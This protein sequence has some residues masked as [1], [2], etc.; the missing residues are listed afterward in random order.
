MISL[1]KR[2]HSCAATTYF[3]VGA[4]MHLYMAWAWVVHPRVALASLLKECLDTVF[5]PI[6][7]GMFLDFY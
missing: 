1:R 6:L 3:D 4:I 7:L 2:T 5:Y